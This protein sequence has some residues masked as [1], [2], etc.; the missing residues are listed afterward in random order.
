MMEENNKKRVVKKLLVAGVNCIIYAK[1]FRSLGFRIKNS[2]S[3]K[4]VVK[5][6]L[7]LKLQL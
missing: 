7:I 6:Y 1:D 4:V 3:L 5:K 2:V